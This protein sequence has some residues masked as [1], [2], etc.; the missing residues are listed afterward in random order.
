[1][2]LLLLLLVGSSISV[3]GATT[4]SFVE[5]TMT[6]HLSLSAGFDHLTYLLGQVNISKQKLHR[7]S[8]KHDQAK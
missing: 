5:P 6:R 1:M 8:M 2:R 7:L 3:S 4:A